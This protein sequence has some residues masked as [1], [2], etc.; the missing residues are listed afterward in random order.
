M[1]NSVRP[2]TELDSDRRSRKPKKAWE[3][4]V[5]K[6]RPKFGFFPTNQIKSHGYEAEFQPGIQ[7][8]DRYLDWLARQGRRYGG[9]NRG[10]VGGR[11]RELHAI[12][13]TDVVAA[14]KLS[15]L[16]EDNRVVP[17][18]ANTVLRPERQIEE[19]QRLQDVADQMRRHEDLGCQHQK[20]GNVRCSENITES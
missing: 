11:S 14:A 2:R 5:Q 7:I 16:L 18:N 9:S 1:R 8:Q 13:H 20:F 17:L 12:L 4:E 15:R 6:G 19:L 10:V 3:I